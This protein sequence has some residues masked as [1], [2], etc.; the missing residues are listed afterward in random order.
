MADSAIHPGATSPGA[1]MHVVSN[2]TLYL[3]H[4]LDVLNQKLLDVADG[5]CKR[6]LVTMPPRHGKSELISHHLP[7]WYLG[8]YPDRRVMLSSYEANFA[9]SWGRKAR[10]ILEEYGDDIFG[11]T[12]SKK[13]KAADAWEIEGNTGGM[14]TAGV[15]GALT[16][17][18]ADLLV[19]DDPVKSAEEAHSETRRAAIW[20][21]FI[22]TALTRLHPGASVLVVM[23]LW[24]ED[25][26][27]KRIMRELKHEGWE[28]LRL[29]AMAEED[30]PLGREV[31]EPLWPEQ[32][33][34]EELERIKKRSS[35]WWAALYQCR[36]APAEGACFKRE[37]IRRW[38]SKDKNYLAGGETAGF[39]DMYRFA[40]V[41]FASSLTKKADY[42]A[43][44]TFG[45]TRGGKLLLLDM[46]R[47]RMEG[48]AIID[49]IKSAIKNNDLHTVFA[50]TTVLNM[51][52]AFVQLL[53]AEGLPV[54][55]MKADKSKELRA[56]AAQP[57]CE[58]GRLYFPAEAPWLADFEHEWLSFP[59]AAHDDMLDAV[60]M[61]CLAAQANRVRGTAK[62]DPEVPHD[63]ISQW[64]A[65][66]LERL[67]GKKRKGIRCE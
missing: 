53:R 63:A 12:V 13:S 37:W 60:V 1:L 56:M 38:T 57:F 48:P 55:A 22:S 33:P 49:A 32:W 44:A 10:E 67:Y 58:N 28:I 64:M 27:G 20:E 43:I 5:T 65:R 9:A 41:D 40:T 62:A 6:L 39:E 4:H 35:Y 2:R 24:H 3:P 61:G 23:T 11:V 54:R 51:Q 66:G 46:Q 59:H 16:G 21:W 17:K 15:G 25:D 26:L 18:G 50:E 31:G 7:A 8:R 45:L 29:P 19:V 14:V 34:I 47:R 36:P 42:T 52:T 30:D